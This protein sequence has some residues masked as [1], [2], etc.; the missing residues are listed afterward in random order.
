MSI[1]QCCVFDLPLCRSEIF[2]HLNMGTE[3]IEIGLTDTAVTVFLIK[4]NR[5]FL[6]GEQNSAAAFSSDFQIQSMHNIASKMTAPE[7][8]AHGNSS[9]DKD[10]FLSILIKPAY[11]CRDVFLIKNNMFCRAVRLIKFIGKSLFLHKN[12]SADVL[13]VPG[14]R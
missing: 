14:E 13:R 1:W 9:G 7:F 5:L 6:G 4:R 11:G 12:F 8:F 10:A 2:Y 3:F